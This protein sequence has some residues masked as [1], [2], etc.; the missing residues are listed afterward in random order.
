MK[1]F[2]YKI[3]N[4]LSELLKKSKVDF[5]YDENK[6]KNRLMYSLNDAPMRAPS[7]NFLRI[8]IVRYSASFAALLIFFSTTFAFA[9][10]SQPGD[11]LFTLNKFGEN[12]VLNLP[13]SVEQNAKM[14][15]H[16]VAKRLGYLQSLESS[17]T[18]EGDNDS[19]DIKLETIRESEES[20]QTAI[21]TIAT[22]KQR[23]QA[24]GK[25]VAAAQLDLALNRLD[26]L[27]SAHEARIHDIEDSSEDEHTK[28]KIE[29][30]LHQIQE[31]RHRARVE[32]KLEEEE[33]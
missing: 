7:H 2:N 30:H 26:Q 33:D 31:A 15:E 5:S 20:L 4:K 1:L 23:L 17:E 3:D 14:Q 10:N 9:S 8:R 28:Q 25:T 6:V 13:L 12:V 24:A 16:I 11:K 29:R 19:D 22:N 32:L 27:A 21:E 18:T